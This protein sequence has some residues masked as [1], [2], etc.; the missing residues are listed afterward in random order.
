VLLAETDLVVNNPSGTSAY[1]GYAGFLQADVEFIQGLH[2]FVTPEI[3][4]EDFNG[5]SPSWTLTLTP[6]WFF[7]PHTDIR[8]DLFLQK[9]VR[10][11]SSTT[12]IGFLAMLHFYL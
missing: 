7:A 6:N 1:V 9:S 3:F 5:A 4:R 10:L 11:A 2:V 8:L 12:G